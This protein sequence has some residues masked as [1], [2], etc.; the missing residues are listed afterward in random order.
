MDK[1]FLKECLRIEVIGGKD[2]EFSWPRAIRHAWRQPKRRFLFWWRIASYL[3]H[4]NNKNLK[5]IALKINRNLMRKYGAEIGLGASIG[6]GFYI[7]HYQG[8]VISEKAVIGTNLAIRQNT[9]IGLKNNNTLPIT[10]GDNVNIGANSCIISNGII[11]GDNVTIGAFSFINKN[12]P[13]NC[14]CYTKKENKII[15]NN[16]S[17]S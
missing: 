9:T 5:K 11:I 14:V 2:K 7:G 1:D 3:H 4:T 17:E 13:S 16:N 8:I 12:I 10:I 6:I 15:I